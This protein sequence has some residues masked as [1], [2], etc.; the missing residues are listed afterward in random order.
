MDKDFE[1]WNIEK[2]NIH[3]VS[4]NKYYHPR[5][6]WWCALGVNIGFEQDGK[7]KD[8][9][10]PVLIVK[11][12]SRETCLIVPLTTSPQK[13]KYRKT[14]GSVTGKTSSAVLSQIKVIDTKRLINKIAVLDQQ[15]F[16]TIRKSIKNLL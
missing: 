7:D 8:F 10:R 15:S 6:I 5:D 12:L 9:Q 2:K 13:H 1:N 11:G 3:A 14:I 4:M 16:E